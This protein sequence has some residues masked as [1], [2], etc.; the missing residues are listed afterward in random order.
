MIFELP[1]SANLVSLSA[2]MSIA[3]CASSLA[4][5]TALHSWDSV[6]AVLQ[7]VH[8]PSCR[9]HYLTWAKDKAKQQGT[10][11]SQ[12]EQDRQCSGQINLF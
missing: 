8:V 5:S 7:G 1:L 6:M 2:A 11:S 12:E 3:N 10:V 4:M 9:L